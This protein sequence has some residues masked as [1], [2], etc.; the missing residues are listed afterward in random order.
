MEGPQRT[1]EKATF[2]WQHYA[3]EAWGLGTFMFAAGAVATAL[4]A[5]PQPIAAAVAAHPILGRALFGIA[6]AVTSAA[7]VY[8]RWGARSGAH[9]NP[10]LTLAFAHLRKIHIMD[11]IPYAIAH[12]VGAAIGFALAASLFGRL[13][14]DPPASAIVTKPGM[15][16]AGVA[17]LAEMAIA[18]ILMTVVLVVSNASP[19]IARYT[20]AAA[21]L[22]VG[23]F[24]TFEAPLSG[25]SMNPA[26]TLASALAGHDW[27]GIWIYFTAPPIGMLLAAMTFVRVRGAQAVL[28]GRLNHA[29]SDPCIFRCNYCQRSTFRPE[30]VRPSV[31]Q[32]ALR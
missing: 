24:I 29:G 1:S 31:P 14:L 6:M 2:H 22:C 15:A 16:G 21:A 9:L 18:F 23:L 5:S 25:M 32:I 17:F 10:A 28:C 13:L 19:R 30:P 8:S 7:I 11:A 26:R 12:F 3:I 4:R 27:T 20:G